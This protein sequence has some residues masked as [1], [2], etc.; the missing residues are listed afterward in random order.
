MLDDALN[1]A[2]K[3]DF[4]SSF[5]GLTFEQQKLLELCSLYNKR[6][7]ELVNRFASHSNGYDVKEKDYYISPKKLIGWNKKGLP[8]DRTGGHITYWVFR[9]TQFIGHKEA[10]EYFSK[11]KWKSLLKAED[12][13]RKIV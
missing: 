10:C 2:I 3:K 5:P 8:Y 4:D 11:D 13:L 7:K 1:E 9:L 12:I 6:V